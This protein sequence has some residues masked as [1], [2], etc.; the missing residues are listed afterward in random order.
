VPSK[1]PS[2]EQSEPAQ[3]DSAHTDSTNPRLS[4]R[5]VLAIGGAVATSSLA[6]CNALGNESNS[7]PIYDGDWHSY[8]NGPKNTNYVDGGLPEP[9]NHDY[10]T[11]A[12]WTYVPPVVH[13]GTVYFATNDQI[14]GIA[15]DSGDQWSQRLDAEVSGALAI[16][17]ERDRLYI[18]VEPV[19][20]DSETNTNHTTVVA[21]S[22]TDRAVATTFN[23]GEGKPYGV[24]VVDGDLYVRCATACV[25]LG[26]DGTERWRQPLDPLIYDEYNLGDSTAT[27]IVPAV[28]DDGVY[29]P[30]RDALVKLDPKTGTERW[31]VT[32]DTPYAASVVD[33]KGVIQT[34]WQET[35]AVDYSGDVRWHRDLHSRAAPAVADGDVYVVTSD[36]YELDADSGETNWQTHLPSEGTAAP[37]VTDE[38]VLI[39]SDNVLAFRRD[40]GGMF[41]PNRNRWE[42]SSVQTTSYCSPVVAAGRIFAVSV[43]MGLVALRPDATN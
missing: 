22:L 17:P 29:V 19:Q 1:R 16:D 43:S 33:D 26:P 27:Q 35:V 13:E 12:G 31:R 24:T 37:V 10:L 15:V 38:D 8:G 42:A 28:T 30:D 11:S 20:T 14:V 25:R 3:S 4:R 36:L 5:S 41:G 6:G 40:T 32:V 9:E 21:F 2:I 7:T 23:I 39:A 34:G 18:P